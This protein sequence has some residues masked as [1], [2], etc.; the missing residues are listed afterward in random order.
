M[1]GAVQLSP[2]DFQSCGQQRHSQVKGLAAQGLTT[3]AS[4]QQNLNSGCWM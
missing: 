3:L 2:L 1:N 4:M